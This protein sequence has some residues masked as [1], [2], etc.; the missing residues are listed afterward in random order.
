MVTDHQALRCLH[1]VNDPSSRLMRWRLKLRDY[2]YEIIYKSGKTNKNSA[3]LSRN[4]SENY[5]EGVA[6][7]IRI[8]A[9]SSEQVDTRTSV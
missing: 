5:D 1:S 8:L 2:Q 9:M 6:H 3:A 7:E 4:P